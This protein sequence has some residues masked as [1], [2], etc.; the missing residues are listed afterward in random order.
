MGKGFLANEGLV[1][2]DLGEIIKSACLRQG[3][4]VELSAIVNDSSAALLS[5]AYITP[6][7]RFSLI[8]G[9]GVNIAAHL[10]VTTIDQ[11]KFGDRPSSWHEKASHVII[12]TELGMFG[13]GILPLT[14]WDKLLKAAHPRPDFQPLEQ[15]VSGYYLGEICRLAL[16]DAISTTGIFGGIVPPSLQTPYSLDTE[17]LSLIEAYAYPSPFVS[18]PHN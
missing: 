12:N 11:P 14:K 1:G 5:E 13:H 18:T 15:L 3:L 17:T 16:L 7:T 4:H 9:T 2:Q 10:P 8:L 6:S